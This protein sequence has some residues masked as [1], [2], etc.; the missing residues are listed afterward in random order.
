MAPPRKL[1]IILCVA[2][3]FNFLVDSIKIVRRHTTNAAEIETMIYEKKNENSDGNSDDECE[4][5]LSAALV[6]ADLFF[7]SQLR[8]AI[9]VFSEHT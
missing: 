2:K 7:Q 8:H 1:I 6:H 4:I 9:R 5:S 3:T